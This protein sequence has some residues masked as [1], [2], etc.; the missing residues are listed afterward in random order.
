[1]QSYRSCALCGAQAMTDSDYCYGHQL[2]L[3]KSAT[4]ERQLNL[5]LIFLVII[6]VFAALFA[7]DEA[8][9]LSKLWHGIWNV[10]R[11]QAEGM[12]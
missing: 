3:A 6:L 9:L 4:E 2:I 11:V 12:L 8:I 5:S 7:F 10:L 1:M